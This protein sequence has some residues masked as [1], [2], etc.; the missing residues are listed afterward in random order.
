MSEKNYQVKTRH[1]FNYIVGE[2]CPRCGAQRLTE[3]SWGGGLRCG[4]CSHVFSDTIAGRWGIKKFRGTNFN[5][6]KPVKAMLNPHSKDAKRQA[7]N[8]IAEER[9]N[10]AL[11]QG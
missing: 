7:R 2:Y 4:N 6:K 1:G 11:A 8:A 10:A 9:K 3:Y 5:R